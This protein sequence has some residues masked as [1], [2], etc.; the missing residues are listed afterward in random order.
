MANLDR[1]SSDMIVPIE[2]LGENGIDFLLD[3]STGPTDAFKDL[4]LQMLTEMVSIITEEENTLAIQNA[5]NG[6][7]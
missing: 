4:A 2:Q 3:E 1:F 6:E 5:K 7:K